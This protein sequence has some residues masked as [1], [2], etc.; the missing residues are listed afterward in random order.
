M[1]STPLSRREGRAYKKVPSK[2]LFSEGP[3]CAEVCNRYRPLNNKPIHLG[4]IGALDCGYEPKQRTIL[5]LYQLLHVIK[6]PMASTPLSRR[7]GRAYKK[8]PSKAL[9]SEEPART[10]VSNHYRLLY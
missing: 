1:A 10:E 6:D 2:A 8:V 4:K 3:D 9:F 7:E 5:M